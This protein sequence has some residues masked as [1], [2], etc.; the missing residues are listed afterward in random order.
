MI[1]LYSKNVIANVDVYYI[2]FLCTSLKTDYPFSESIF[3]WLN[4]IYLF[5]ALKQNIK[6][7]II[8]VGTHYDKLPKAERHALIEKLFRDLRCEIAATPLKELVSNEYVVDN[9]KKDDSSFSDI[10]SEIFRLAKLQPNWGKMTPSK[11]LP[12][13]REMQGLKESGLKVMS[14]EQLGY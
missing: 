6:P 7:Q 9:S 5:A 13:E 8:L 14:T 2:L 3:F 1:T 10:Q 12:L 11:W 4:V